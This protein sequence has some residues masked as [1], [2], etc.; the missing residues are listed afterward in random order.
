MAT[1]VRHM[2]ASAERVFDVLADG[3]LYAV[4]VVGASRIREVDSDWPAVGSRIQHSVGAWPLLINDETEV[5]TSQRPH[6]LVLAIKARPIGLARV[7]LTITS[8]GDGDG[9]GA[10]VTMTEVPTHGP[11]RWVH[12][13]ANDAVLKWRNVETLNRLASI[14][15]NRHP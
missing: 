8:D 10:T 13:P 4:W 9:D 5:L 1:V 2:D 11:G 6:T 14:A 3:W 7:T 15:E 12:N